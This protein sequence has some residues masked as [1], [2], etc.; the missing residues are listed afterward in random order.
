MQ[1]K[2]LAALLA[3]I[4]GCTFAALDTVTKPALKG[5][6]ANP[7]QG[8]VAK[9]MTGARV[10]LFTNKNSNAYANKVKRHLE[11]EGKNPES[12]KLGK[13]PWGERVKDTPFIENKGEHYLQVIFLEAGT[14]T[15]RATS[16][17]LD[18]D[19]N[20]LYY[21]GQVIDRESVQ[22]LSERTG[23]EHQGLENEVIVRTFKIDSI[24][25]IRAFQEELN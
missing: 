10:M 23:S 12:F 24:R 17:I 6:K 16:R 15:Y 8:K 20:L 7:M 22:G 4:E 9:H 19:G 13:L 2:E 5:G 21:T 11:K 3:R 18:G 25:S 14:V 1:Y